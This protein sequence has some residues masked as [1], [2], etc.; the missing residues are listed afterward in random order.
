MTAVP[1]GF[2][3]FQTS[4]VGRVTPKTAR[5]FTAG[6]LLR[7]TTSCLALAPC[8]P[9]AVPGQITISSA[10]LGPVAAVAGAR[11]A[12]SP[13]ATRAYRHDRRRRGFCVV[14]KEMFDT[15]YP[16][17]PDHQARV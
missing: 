8:E 1:F 11:P 7:S 2:C 12:A 5:S 17:Y 16:P 6:S 13:S 9:G 15:L 3:G 10:P 4:R 14:L